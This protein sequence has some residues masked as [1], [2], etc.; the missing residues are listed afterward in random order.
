MKYALT[1]DFG[2]T[3]AKIVVVDLAERRIVLSD[4]VPSSVGTDATI[5]MRQC[6]DLAKEAIGPAEF[7]KARKLASSSAA[8]GLRMAV[9][10]LTGSLSTPASRSAALGAGAKI[11]ANY[12][13]ALSEDMVRE[14]EESSAEIILLCGGYERGNTSM[15]LANADM[16]ARSAIR[17]PVIYAGNSSLCK[18]V[19]AMMRI[20]RKQCFV[21]ENIIPEPGVQNIAPTQEVIRNLFLDTITDMKGFQAVKKAF[22]NPLV[23]T[24]VAVLAAGDLLNRG[25]STTPGFGPLLLVDV[26]GATTDVYSFNENTCFEGA[27][28][29]GLEEPFGKRTVEGDLGMRESSGGVIPEYDVG[30][31][32]GELSIHEDRLRQSIRTRMT[33]VNY[34]PDSETETKIDDTIASLT[35][36]AATRRH[37]GRVIPSYSKKCQNIQIG[38][39]C[40]DITTIIGTGGILVHT[41]SP[42]KIL[43]AAEKNGRDNGLLLPCRV[44]AY[45]DAEYVLFS[46]G[47]LRQMDE[48][49]ALD[50]M[51]HSLT[52]CER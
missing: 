22:D 15:V 41:R 1:V 24:P 28:P 51:K 16:L 43:R 2:S 4:T 6:F 50:I 40:C 48:D 33:A 49:V 31:I 34:L 36:S 11:I 14:L 30:R 44:E 25:T 45:L 37:A 9:S 47:L 13:G 8:G 17:V 21:M 20:H 23:P 35:V 7:A 18:E 39:N 3:F 38:K 42:A 32:A 19:R 52:R 29:V 5:G 12:S 27:R 26:G 10:G 46:A